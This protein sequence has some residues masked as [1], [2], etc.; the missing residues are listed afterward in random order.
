MRGRKPCRAETSWCMDA[1]G[2]CAAAESGTPT[3]CCV[4]GGGAW[5]RLCREAFP[6]AELRNT[7]FPPCGGG[8]VSEYWTYPGFIST[9]V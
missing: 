5:G 8:G 2:S 7:R 6:A 9:R 1:G 4:W 3:N